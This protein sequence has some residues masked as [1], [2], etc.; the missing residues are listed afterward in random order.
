MRFNN[1]TVKEALESV[2][3]NVLSNTS[4]SEATL[5][6]RYLCYYYYPLCD[7]ETDDVVSMCIGSCQMLNDNPELSGVINDVAEE[8][9]SFDIEPPDNKCSKSFH[10]QSDNFPVSQFCVRTEGEQTLSK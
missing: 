2:Q 5:M 3:I 10:G 1:E 6:E 4:L 7:T 9:N 8:L